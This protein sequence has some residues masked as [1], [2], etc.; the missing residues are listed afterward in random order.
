M[1]PWSAGVF[2]VVKKDKWEILSFSDHRGDV[3]GETQ[4]AAMKG[5]S[6]IHYTNTSLVCGGI[7][8]RDRPDQSD[9]DA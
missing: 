8:R 5:D 4:S 6:G 7:P 9:F 2:V 1:S 3:V